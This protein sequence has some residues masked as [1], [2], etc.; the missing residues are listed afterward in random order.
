MP[1][2]QRGHIYKCPCLKQITFVDISEHLYRLELVF[3]SSLFGQ[4]YLQKN[5]VE[6]HFIFPICLENEQILHS[7][8]CS[9][10]LHQNTV[11]KK[12]VLK[13]L[14]TEQSYFAIFFTT[15]NHPF[16][17]IMRLMSCVIFP[18]GEDLDAILYLNDLNYV[19]WTALVQK[20]TKS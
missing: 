1:V 16:V 4:K 6:N 2:Y 3:S 10:Q 20:I 8:A 7:D 19:K 15:S 9:I 13:I 14:W 18:F 17:S 5:P 11:I 12:K